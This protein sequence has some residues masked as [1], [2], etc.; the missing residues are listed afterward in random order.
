MAMNFQQRKD[1]VDFGKGLLMILVYVYHSEVIIGSQ[2]SFSWWFAPFFLTGFFF[3]SGYLYTS[4]IRLVNFK[5]KL[6]Q[7]FR[8]IF[9]IC[10]FYGVHVRAQNNVIRY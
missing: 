8:T 2:H 7:V 3:L 6:K 9:A 5:E 1:W 4:N 10:H